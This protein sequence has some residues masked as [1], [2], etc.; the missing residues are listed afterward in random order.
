MN[1]D[2]KNKKKISTSLLYYTQ[3]IENDCNH[4]PVQFVLWRLLGVLLQLVSSSLWLYSKEENILY[5]W[6]QAL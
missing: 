2:Q 6:F 1:K 3:I 5:I 4:I